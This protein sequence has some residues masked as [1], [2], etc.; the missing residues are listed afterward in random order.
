MRLEFADP[1]LERLATDIRYQHGLGPDVVKS[2]RKA[3]GYLT[4]CVDERDIRAIRGYHFKRL[5][6]E[7][8][9]QWSMRLNDQFRLIVEIHRDA[10]GK[11]V[12]LVEVVDYH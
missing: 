2:F 12:V 8:S 5:E 6:G 10:E 4:K 11:V 1:K 9:H 7:R 3:V